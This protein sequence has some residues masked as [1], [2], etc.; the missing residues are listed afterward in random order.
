MCPCLPR[1]R[2]PHTIEHCGCDVSESSQKRILALRMSPTNA[3]AWH[4]ALLSQAVCSSKGC[5]FEQ[6][7][8]KQESFEPARAGSPN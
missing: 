3:V 4:C 6:G 8:F 1:Q 7:L 2:A 5:L